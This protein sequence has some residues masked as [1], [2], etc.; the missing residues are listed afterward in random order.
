MLALAG[1]RRGREPAPLGDRVRRDRALQGRCCTAHVPRPST[2]GDTN[3]RSDSTPHDRDG[4]RHRW[5]R[6]LIQ[7]FATAS[8]K[9]IG[10]ARLC[11]V[12]RS[13]KNYARISWRSI[14][15]KLAVRP[16]VLRV[17]A[18]AWGL[19]HARENATTRQW[20]AA[21]VDR[22]LGSISY[23]LGFSKAELTPRQRLPLDAN[24]YAAASLAGFQL[25]NVL[26][27]VKRRSRN[28]ARGGPDVVN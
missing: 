22:H 3:Q 8:R 23:R 1:T 20:N 17:P 24:T 6:D 25:G 2:A 4:A 18:I 7:G 14:F 9:P 16:C 5:R 13:R 10:Q 12:N 26:L 27:P 15:D 28:A 11:V 21:C 19:P